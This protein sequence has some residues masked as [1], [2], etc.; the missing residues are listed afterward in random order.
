MKTLSESS[1][2]KLKVVVDTNVYIATALRPGS[3]SDDAL[4]LIYKG[5]AE[6]YYSNET[7]AEL[8]NQLSSERFQIDSKIIQL[9]LGNIEAEG[10]F[11]KTLPVEE[12]R[13][14]DP[15]DLHIIECAVAARANLII[16]FD[17]D[18]LSLK[19][20]HGIGIVHPK[21]FCWMVAEE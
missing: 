3:L 1:G 11:V 4:R 14:R 10:I 7:L 19:D 17:K 2:A 21:S 15:N 16:T 6:L 13:L 9:I 12:R 20:S 8:K 5:Y 18:L